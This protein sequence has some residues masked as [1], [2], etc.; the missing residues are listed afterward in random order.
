M[1]GF[2]RAE[3]IQQGEVRSNKTKIGL[4]VVFDEVDKYDSS[5]LDH[6]IHIFRAEEG[7]KQRYGVIIK[8]RTSAWVVSSLLPLRSF[9]KRSD[10]LFKL[11]Q[12]MRRSVLLHTKKDE[13]LFDE[14]TEQKI[15][16]VIKGKKSQRK[17]V[18]E[19]KKVLLVAGV[20]REISRRKGVEVE[21]PEFAKKVAK[22]ISRGF[23]IGPDVEW[24]LE[25]IRHVHLLARGLAFSKGRTVIKKEDYRVV[26][27]ILSRH[28]KELGVFR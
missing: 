2:F 7:V 23:H 17:D 13:S 9:R 1:K 20:S 24:G 10:K 8:A 14:I 21:D 26:Y 22:K 27:E 16:E 5:D 3:E 15:K 19:L 6:L 28:G 25:M 12:L 18:M 11:K 4:K